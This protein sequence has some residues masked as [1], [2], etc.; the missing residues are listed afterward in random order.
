[1]VLQLIDERRLFCPL[2]EMDPFRTRI[3]LVNH[4]EEAH[5]ESLGINNTAYNSTCNSGL[6]W[7]FNCLSKNHHD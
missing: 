3:E 7:V 6:S 2:C 1:M 5:N 4:C